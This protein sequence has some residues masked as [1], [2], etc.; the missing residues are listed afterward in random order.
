MCNMQGSIYHKTCRSVVPRK[1][2]G[3][4]SECGNNVHKI[5][6]HSRD[7]GVIS[8]ENYHKLPSSISEIVNHC[9]YHDMKYTD[10]FQHHD[11]PCCPDC[12]STNLKNCVGLL[13]I[14]EIIKT[15]KT[16]T[17]IDNIE[18]RLTYIKN[19]IDKITKNRQQNIS[20]IR[21]QR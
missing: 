9:E 18:Q 2:E 6:K 21:H 15:F 1:Y 13:S 3:L 16:S 14:R 8:L 17:S 4:C 7:Y 10:Y 11:K 20:E 5:S 12:T 19:N